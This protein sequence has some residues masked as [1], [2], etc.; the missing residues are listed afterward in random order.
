M[1]MMTFGEALRLLKEKKRVRRMSWKDGEYLYL[2]NSSE[3]KV[4]R[5]PLM[6][7]YQEGTKIKYRAHI[8]KDDGNGVC[9][10]YCF[11]QEDILEE[12]WELLTN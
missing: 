6:G 11:S 12:D 10:P 8:D 9:V 1:K 4:N 2:V 5:K 7:L 3:F